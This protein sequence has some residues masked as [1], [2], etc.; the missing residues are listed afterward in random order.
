MNITLPG[1]LGTSSDCTG[2]IASDGTF[3]LERIPKEDI[4][5]RYS[6]VVS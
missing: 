5:G 4:V 3:A 6:G 2:T 1:H